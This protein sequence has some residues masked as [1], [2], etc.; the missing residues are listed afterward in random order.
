MSSE[1]HSSVRATYGKAAQEPAEALCCPTRYNP[2]DLSHIPADVLE[3]SYGC[4]SP[5]QKAD[6]QA[7]MSVVDLG[8]GG[9]ID[10]FIAAKLAGPK[11]S[12]YGIDMTDEM[13]A[14]AK[15]NSGAVSER[16]GYDVVQFR[17]GML[18]D[19]PLGDGIADRVV[20]NCVLNLSPD[21]ERVFAEIYRVLKDGGRFVISDI[22]SDKPATEEMRRNRELWGECVSGALTLDGFVKTAVNTGFY[23]IEAVHD[24][25]WKEVE[26][27][28]FHSYTITGYKLARDGACVYKG[29][30][31]TY[32]G[33][34][35]QVTDDEGHTYMRGIPL[36]ICTGTY[37]RL[38]QPP[39]AGLFVIAEGDEAAGSECCGGGAVT[40]CC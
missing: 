33:P 40:S 2:A 11:G 22:V 20:S 34:F 28:V 16:L 36:E 31:A 35:S 9:G 18:E 26:G 3:I 4:G 32:I 12:V 15:E 39:Y 14:K 5:I 7:G 19:I 23:G 6:V 24:Y 1:I 10:C 27:I 21:K 29:Q 38:H 13:L 30:T 17:K 37:R 8:S 25:L